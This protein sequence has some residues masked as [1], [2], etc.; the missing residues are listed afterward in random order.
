MKKELTIPEIKAREKAI[1]DFIDSV[2]K[3]YGITYYLDG[4]TLLGAIRHKGFIPWDDDVDIIVKRSDY[5]RL[6]D[7]IDAEGHGR[8]RTLSVRSQ[9]DY[10][11]WFA[12]TVDTE[13]EL[14]EHENA[15]IQDLG[16]Y[17]DI[18]PLEY[19]PDD[20]KKMKRFK[21]WVIFNRKLIYNAV[22][23]KSGH[24]EKKTFT[25]VLSGLVGLLI[26]WR[27]ILLHY[28]KVCTRRAQTPTSNIGWTK[29]FP[30]ACF[31]KPVP[32]TF[33]GT[34]YPAPT[35]YDTYLRVLYGDYMQ[36]PPE[37]QRNSGHNFTAW[38]KENEC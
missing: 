31:G 35:D 18:F 20:E 12:K 33:E 19:K 9:N 38:L 32:V 10:Y 36:L 15:D 30:A 14:L 16:V 6:L 28:D 1:L 11:Y 8:Y 5:Q 7:A 21:N 37:D 26:G 22:D 34:E 24:M 29:T 3:K 13:T 17:V 23:L 27:R 4:G 2:A 25:S